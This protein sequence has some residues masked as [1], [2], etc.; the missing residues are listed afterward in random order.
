[1]EE[2]KTIIEYIEQVMKI[3]GFSIIML[4]IFC[5]LFGES[6]RD[7][8][9]M[10]AMGNEGL[11]VVTMLQFLTLAVWIVFCRFLF[12]TD[13][14]I[15]NMRIV[16]RACCMLGA[17][18]IVMVICI[19]AFQWFPKDYWLPWVMFFISFLISFVVSLAV[20]AFKEKSENKRMEEALEKMIKRNQQQEEN[21][22]KENGGKN[23]I[24]N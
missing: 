22:R 4:N 11:R 7:F 6:A 2:R 3:F 19:T 5:I 24:R 1:M 17:I 15:K 10:F 16:W 8:S 13:I 14:M 21:S 12:F 20:T 23:G 18:L 9:S